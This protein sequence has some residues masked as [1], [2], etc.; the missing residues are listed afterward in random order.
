MEGMNWIDLAQDRD[1]CT[2][3]PST[4]RLRGVHRECLYL[5]CSVLLSWVSNVMLDKG[6]GHLLYKFSLYL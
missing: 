5:R 1:R 2:S 6:Q 3:I 4:I